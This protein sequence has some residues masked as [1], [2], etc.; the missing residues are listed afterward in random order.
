MGHFAQLDENNVVTNVIVI[1][2]N[3]LLDNGIESEEKGIAF[4]KSLYGQDTRWVQTSFNRT[5]R[6][7][8]AGIGHIYDSVRDAFR[9]E[10]CHD[11]ATL[12]EDTCHWECTNAAHTPGGN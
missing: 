10:P 4:C 6:K 7:N 5:F 11:E 1:N 9:S 3:E 2:N 8:F 12:N